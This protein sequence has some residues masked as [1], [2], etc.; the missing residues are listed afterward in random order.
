MT[1]DSMKCA[2]K[3]YNPSRDEKQQ[4]HFKKVVFDLPIISQHRDLVT[5]SKAWI[6]FK[7]E[8]G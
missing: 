3:C 6:K 2:T 4:S 7:L 8:L 5:Q 1:D